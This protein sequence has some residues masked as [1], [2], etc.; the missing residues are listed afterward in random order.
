MAQMYE[1]RASAGLL[2]AEAT[3]IS[4]EARGFP[5]TPGCF[6]Q[7]HE[8]GWRLVTDAVHKKGGRI[9]LQ[10]WHQG[11]TSNPALN[12]GIVPVCPTAYEA[13]S[14]A[15][16]FGGRGGAARELTHDDI[17]RILG[18]YKANAEHALKAGF[19]GVEL[20]SAN[21]YLVNQFLVDGVNKRTDGYGGGPEKRVRFLSEALDALTSVFG[22]DRVGVRLSPTS[23]WQDITD[24]D[25]VG[26]YTCVASTLAAKNLAYVHIVEPRDTGLG[27]PDYTPAELTLTGEWFKKALPNTPIL[28]AGGH[29]YA[30][31]TEYLASGGVDAVVYGRHFIPNPDLVARFKKSAE[32]GG[33]DFLTPYDRDTFYGG[34]ANG[35]E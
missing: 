16:G 4:E 13:E 31:G 9:F 8:D 11:R 15:N 34:G 29:T 19:D 21:G 10:L 27:S 35:C 28:S 23:H 32:N 30:S 26:L 2:I 5:N 33:K 18:E 24:S 7:E 25:P 6:T 17:Q 3:V 1:A 12:G 22:S 20:H 14:W